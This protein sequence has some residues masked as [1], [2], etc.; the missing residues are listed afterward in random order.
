MLNDGSVK[1][2]PAIADYSLLVWSKKGSKLL[3]FWRFDDAI[4]VP[5]REKS[6]KECKID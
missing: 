2:G 5:V 6:K 3:H 4:Q 1:D